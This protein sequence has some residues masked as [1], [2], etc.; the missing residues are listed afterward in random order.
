LA[1][2]GSEAAFSREIRG[3]CGSIFSLFGV[4]VVVIQLHLGGTLIGT[5]TH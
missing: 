5:D 1:R 4:L 2:G 3:L